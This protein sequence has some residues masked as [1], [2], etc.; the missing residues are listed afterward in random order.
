M[1]NVKRLPLRDFT[2][3]CMSIAQV[4]TSYMSGLTIEEQILWLCSYLTNEVIPT[5]N[6]NGQAVEELQ[7]LY[8]QLKDY[9]DNYFDN[10]DIQTEVN[11]K[12]E[13]M[14]ESGQLADIIAQYI[15]LQG[16]LAYN[17]VADLKS[18]ENVV[19]G[20]FA[21]TY[22]YHSYNDN[23]GAFYKIRE[24]Q[25]TDVEDDGSII[26]LSNPDLVAELIESDINVKQFGAYGDN[27]H[28][29]T[30]AFQTAL[31]YINKTVDKILNIPTGDYLIS[32]TLELSGLNKLIGTDKD[33]T[34][35]FQKTNDC[36]DK[37]IIATANDTNAHNHIVLKD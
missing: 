16:V 20:S 12:L 13:D 33:R 14:A 15:Q 36:L 28:D 2:R 24:V 31:V 5:V 29:D 35:I 1:D 6:N 37:P 3:F 30:L 25:N 22:G 8:V 19:D 9:V 34:R 10:L 17:T 26:A 4:P 32:D 18:A 23:G 7:T 27:T 21:R 11:N